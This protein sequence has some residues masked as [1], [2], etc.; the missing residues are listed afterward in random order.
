V[1][2]LAAYQSLTPDNHTVMKWGSERTTEL[3]TYQPKKLFAGLESY[4]C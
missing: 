1:E 4:R 3:N 2:I